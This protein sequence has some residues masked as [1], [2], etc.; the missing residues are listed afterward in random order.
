MC[1]DIG[2]EVMAEAA[3]AAAAAAGREREEEGGEVE[4]VRE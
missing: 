2:T 1:N 3:T 4:E